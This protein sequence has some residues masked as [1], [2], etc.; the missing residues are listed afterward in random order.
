MCIRDSS[1]TSIQYPTK[2]AIGVG[3]VHLA[4]HSN[5]T[6]TDIKRPIPHLPHNSSGVGIL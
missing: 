3:D 1:D 5:S 2:M 4:S 6:T